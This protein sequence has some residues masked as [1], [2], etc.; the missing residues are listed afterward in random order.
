MSAGTI[1]IEQVLELLVQ[2]IEVNRRLT[3]RVEM[4]EARLARYE[5]PPPKDVSGSG[6]PTDYSVAADEQR[7]RGRRKKQKSARR[8]R[9]PTEDKLAEVARH[10]ASIQLAANTNASLI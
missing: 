5:P 9:L 6:T 4:L 10:T 7:R 8:G 1:T 3:A 2:Q